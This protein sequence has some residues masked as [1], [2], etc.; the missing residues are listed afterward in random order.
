MMLNVTTIFKA[1]SGEYIKEVLGYT[2]L[3]SFDGAL[4]ELIFTPLGH[5]LF[6]TVGFPDDLALS[7]I[8]IDRLFR[9]ISQPV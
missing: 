7:K 9:D 8:H 2:S 4:I 6:Y 5:Q 1:T 3:Y